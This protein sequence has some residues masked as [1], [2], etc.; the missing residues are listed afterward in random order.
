M[1]AVIMSHMNGLKPF[2]KTTEQETITPSSKTITASAMM[3]NRIT[4]LRELL[5]YHLRLPFPLEFLVT[6]LVVGVDILLNHT[7]FSLSLRKPLTSIMLM[8]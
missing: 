8:H 4:S 2:E 3:T 6:L 1:A 7:M 5:H